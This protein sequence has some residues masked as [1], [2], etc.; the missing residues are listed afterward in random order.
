MSQSAYP[1]PAQLAYVTKAG[2]ETIS[3][4]KTFTTLD[5]STPVRIQGAVSQTDELLFV[6]TNAVDGLFTVGKDCQVYVAMPFGVEPDYG[7]VE[8]GANGSQVK[9]LT[10]WSGNSGSKVA[11]VEVDG[12]ITSPTIDDIQTMAWLQVAP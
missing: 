6:S 1:V 12:R 11:S 2:V 7:T 8:I 4:A 5:G 3:G 10:Y 9:P